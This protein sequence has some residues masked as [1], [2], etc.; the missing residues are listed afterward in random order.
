M[1]TASYTYRRFP[2]LQEVAQSHPGGDIKCNG[3]S[4]AASALRHLLKTAVGF[5]SYYNENNREMALN[6]ASFFCGGVLRTHVEIGH[7]GLP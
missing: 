4:R 7:F 3:P 6:S 1:S 2:T 5:S